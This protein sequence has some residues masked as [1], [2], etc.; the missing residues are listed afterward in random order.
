MD[1]R[2]IKIDCCDTRKHRA[3][4][5]QNTLKS[6]RPESTFTEIASQRRSSSVPPKKKSKCDSRPARPRSG[7]CRRAGHQTRGR[8]GSVAYA[9]QMAS[10]GRGQATRTLRPADGAESGMLP[11]EDSLRRARP[12]RKSKVKGRAGRA[13]SRERSLLDERGSLG[14]YSRECPENARSWKQREK[15][16]TPPPPARPSTPS[17]PSSAGRRTCAP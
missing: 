9:R 13:C 16:L 8:T 14:P 2:S 6:S 11:L 10:G 12:H 3:S 5:V 15:A 4:T 17:T 7:E 1:K